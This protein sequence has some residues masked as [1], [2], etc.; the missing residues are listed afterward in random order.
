MSIEISFNFLYAIYV[1]GNVIN[2]KFYIY[3]YIGYLFV[4]HVILKYIS[5]SKSKHQMKYVHKWRRHERK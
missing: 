2:R 4:L 1:L 5:L 3:I